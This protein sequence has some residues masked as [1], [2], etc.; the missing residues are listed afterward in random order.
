MSLP[1][2]IDDRTPTQGRGAPRRSG[3]TLVLSATA[4]AGA[5]GYIITWLVP[6]VVGFADYAGFAVFWS[7][8]F[9]VV[10]ALSGIQQEMTRATTP[11]VRDTDADTSRA[12]PAVFAVGAAVVVVAALASTAQLWGTAFDASSAAL[13]LPLTFGAASSVFVAMLT[14]TMYG[15]RRW[16]GIFWIVVIEAAVRLVAISIAVALTS[17]VVV[18]AWTVVIPFPIAFTVVWLV[19]RRGLRGTTRL[20]VGYRD[21]TWN[22]ARTIVAAGSM[23]VLVSGFPFVLALTAGDV[24]DTLLGLVVAAATLVRAPLIVTAMALQSYLIVFFRERNPAILRPFLLIQ[25]GVLG[26]GLLLGVIGWLVGPAIF[27]LLFP[28]QPVPDGWLIAVL[29]VS[30][31]L[32]AGLT[33]SAAAVL[34]RARHTAYTAGWVVAAGATILVLLL[35]LDFIDRTIIALLVGPAAG[36]LVHTVA[37]SRARG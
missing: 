30:S 14:G 29:V 22:V 34:S 13:I 35:P 12:R 11:V 3:L 10:N 9:L 37:L 5:T 7:L 17:D 15:V 16:V 18:L 6:R 27:A 2:P 24:S 19:G 1:E 23:G 33:V 4:I 36:L 28:S 25:A 32:L 26:L 8:L 20:D 31:S 21:L